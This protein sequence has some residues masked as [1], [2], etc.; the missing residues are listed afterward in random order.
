MQRFI[1]GFVV[2]ALLAGSAAM[3]AAQPL[4]P[5]QAK[6]VLFKG[7]KYVIEQLEGVD[8]GP[9][10]GVQVENFLNAMQNPKVARQMQ[11]MGFT[12]GYYGAM[13]VQPGRPLSDKTMVLSNNLHSPEAASAAA[14]RACNALEGPEC[15]SVALILPRRYKPRELTLSHAA[16]ESFR[17]Q[18]GRPKQ[19]QYLAYSPS[20]PAF[21]IARGVGADAVAIE[22]CNQ[23]TEGAND[24]VIAIAQ[25]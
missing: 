2:A 3:A 14:L 21:V 23:A 22:K 5:K 13:A 25:E 6:R 9:V 20:T 12:V 8:V 19:P 24:C 17:D 7:D 11:A 15:V 18:W 16:T 1:K 4:E 10:T